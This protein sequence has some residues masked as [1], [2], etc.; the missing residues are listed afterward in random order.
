MNLKW[1]SL[2][3]MEVIYFLVIIIRVALLLKP[4][5]LPINIFITDRWSKAKDRQERIL[6]QNVTNYLINP[7]LDRKL[8]NEVGLELSTFTFHVHCST[9][10]RLG[11]AS[12][13]GVNHNSYHFLR[14]GYIQ[15]EIVMSFSCTDHVITLNWH[16]TA[17]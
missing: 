3:K 4:I 9:S 12:D 10:Y 15:N 17:P 1:R 8:R 14:A 2:R 16:P 6:Y 5:I 7:K 13:F 11:T